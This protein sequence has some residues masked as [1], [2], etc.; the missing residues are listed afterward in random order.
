MAHENTY[1][2]SFW[3]IKYHRAIRYLMQ[4]MPEKLQGFRDALDVFRVRPGFR[5]VVTPGFLKSEQLARSLQVAHSLELND[6]EDHE[7]FTFGRHIKHNHPFFT[8]LQKD[9]TG[10]VSDL[11]GEP[12]E[13]SYN[14]LSFYNDLGNCEL[15]MD[16]P[17]SKWTLDICLEQ[18]GPWPLFVSEVMPWLDD[19]ALENGVDADAVKHATGFTEY[20]MS[21]GDAVF[22]GGSSQ[23]HYRNRIPRPQSRNF[24]TLIFLHYI[25]AGATDLASPELW[26]DRFNI[27]ELT[28]VIEDR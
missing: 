27:P 26:A 1:Y 23:W 16:A 8:D 25:P 6:L 20:T 17:V 7:L 18:S 3:L 5:E 4:E 10:L 13:P 19:A 12:L 28:S 24:C 21:P 14:F 22:F 9:L 15:H 2:D 11:A